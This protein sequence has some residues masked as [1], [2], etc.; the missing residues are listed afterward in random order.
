MPTLTPTPLPPPDFYDSFDAGIRSEW[1]FSNQD[2]A[3]IG[4]ELV[5]LQDNADVRI[6]IGHEEW[7]DYSVE[8]DFVYV[9]PRGGNLSKCW[10]T[11]MWT[12]DKHLR[13]SME[14][15]ASASGGSVVWQR[16]GEELP[17]TRTDVSLLPYSVKVT[18]Q[19]GQIM[20]FIDGNSMPFNPLYLPDHTHGKIGMTCSREGSALDIFQSITPSL[21][22]E[23]VLVMILIQT[24]NNHEKVHA[25][26]HAL[27]LHSHALTE[28]LQFNNSPYTHHGRFSFS[29]ST[30]PCQSQLSLRGHHAPLLWL[31]RWLLQLFLTLKW[32]L[33]CVS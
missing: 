21:K 32:W 14:H 5:S 2:W 7:K 31:F 27:F 8:F 26:G 15:R 11:I 23:E 12:G 25:V 24:V 16:D 20:T 18:A 28:S 17:N 29:T 9:V 30:L 10:L 1:E 19:D 4:G 3:S 13:L 22:L 33:P 6:S